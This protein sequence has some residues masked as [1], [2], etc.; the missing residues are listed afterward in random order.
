MIARRSLLM[1][2]GI[3]KIMRYPRIA[4]T[5]ANAMPVFPL[6]ASIKVSPG[7]ISPRASARK[8]IL[9]AGRSLTDPA[10]LWLSSFASS[11]LWPESGRRCSRTNGV[12][13][14]VSSIRE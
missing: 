1:F 3:S 13:P 8:T 5:M 12:D 2:S 11:V 9:C 10:G 14:M 6:V 7:L 4:A